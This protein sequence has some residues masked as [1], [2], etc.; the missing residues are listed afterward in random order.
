MSAGAGGRPPAPG[1]DDV[2]ILLVPYARRGEAR[3]LGAT[4]DGGLRAW[5][6]PRRAA[7]DMPRG[8]LPLRDRPGLAPP[9]LRINLVPQTS[10][11]RNLRALMDKEA[12]S[13]F[14]R[15]HVY[16]STG[17]LCLV[18]GGRG[19]DWPVEAD[20]VWHFDDATGMQRLAAVVPLCPACHEVRSAGLATANGRARDAARHLAWVERIT[21]A[22]AKRRI[23]EALQVWVARS[24]RKWTI[25]VSIMSERYGIDVVHDDA[26]TR[27]VNAQLVAEARE[28]ARNGRRGRPGRRPS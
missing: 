24:R 21:Q 10:W 5:T 8:L 26:V 12:W 15:T 13:S 3:G 27:D 16:R 2:Q 22:A 20:E 1:P 14:A 19:P 18:C 6:M 25:D 9:I 11:G 23:D 4:W 28:R 17:S 7:A